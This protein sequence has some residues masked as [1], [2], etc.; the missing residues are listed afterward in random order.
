LLATRTRLRPLP[1]LL[2]YPSSCRLR[3]LGGFADSFSGVCCDGKLP[4]FLSDLRLCSTSSFLDRSPLCVRYFFFWIIVVETPGSPLPAA[5]ISTG[6]QPFIAFKTK[7]APVYASLVFF[8]LWNFF[9]SAVG[10]LILGGGLLK[11]HF[12]HARRFRCVPDAM[13]TR[14]YFKAH[15]AFPFSVLSLPLFGPSRPLPA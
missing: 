9:I 3:A 6:G 4:R 5:T 14:G 13:L 1:P 11:Q 2:T 12:R 8:F 15:S 10:R 7:L